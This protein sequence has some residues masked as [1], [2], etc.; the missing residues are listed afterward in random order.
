MWL[1][2]YEIMEQKQ[3]STAKYYCPATK[4][5]IDLFPI[6]SNGVW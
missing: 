2:R 5:A 3:A 1:Q 6:F 4:N